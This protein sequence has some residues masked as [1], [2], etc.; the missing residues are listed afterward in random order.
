MKLGNLQVFSFEMGM[1]DLAS[2]WPTVCLL[3]IESLSDEFDWQK[4]VGLYISM[5]CEYFMILGSA[6]EDVHEALDYA[7]DDCNLGDLG[8]PT[9]IH[10]GESIDDVVWF[11]LNSAIPGEK[12]V[13]CVFGYDYE[14][15]AVRE[16][17]E[18]LRFEYLRRK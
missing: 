3:K 12:D 7:I 13:R 14:D 2:V 18:K 8:I 10:E 1:V 5:G 16:I 6:A 11:L 9:A 4:L 17:L 15:S